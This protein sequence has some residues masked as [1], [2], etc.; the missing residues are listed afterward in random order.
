MFEKPRIT[1][2]RDDGRTLPPAREGIPG[3]I[4]KEQACLPAPPHA[5][6]CIGL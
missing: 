6:R 2:C 5:F 1:L 3:R 4:K